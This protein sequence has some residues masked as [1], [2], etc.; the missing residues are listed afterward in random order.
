MSLS[1]GDNSN[2]TCPTCGRS[3]FK[4]QNGMQMHHSRI[5]GESL[6]KVETK[7]ETCDKSFEIS[8]SE[9]NNGGGK[10]CSNDC[11]AKAQRKRIERECPE[12]GQLFEIVKSRTKLRKYCSNECKNESNKSR[13]EQECDECGQSFEVIQNRVDKGEGKFCSPE[14]SHEA[15]RNKI[16]RE[17]LEC[18]SDFTAQ[19]NQI[20]RGR[21]KYCSTECQYEAYRNRIERECLECR[22]TIRA[23]HSEIEN[24]KGIFCSPECHYEYYSGKNHPRWKGGITEYPYFG[25]VSKREDIIE[26]DDFECRRCGFS[27][28]DHRVVYENGLEVHHIFKIRLFYP[29]RYQEHLKQ[30]DDMGREGISDA[31]YEDLKR[32]AEKAN[33]E[34]NLVTLCKECHTG[35][36]GLES[37]PVERQLEI[38]DI[39]EP[40]YSPEDVE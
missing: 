4:N 19:P 33:H 35:E 18:G 37:K 1:N 9:F 20:R 28:K 32:L 24:G 40:K 27:Q 22:E 39:D 6:T 31:V 30:L 29:D 38:L 13:V 3:D 25:F 8:Q 21:G 17:C 36:D 2:S 10:Y 34:S 23:T 12:C 15:R 7:C 11:Q 16:H 26:R 14:C 5:H